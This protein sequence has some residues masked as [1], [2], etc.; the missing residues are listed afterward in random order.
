MVGVSGQSA[1]GIGRELGRLWK[2]FAVV[3]IN[4]DDC[5]MRKR[6]TT[7]LLA[8]IIERDYWQLGEKESVQDWGRF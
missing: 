2:F 7:K 4:N 5:L 8:E 6:R 3:T 1:L